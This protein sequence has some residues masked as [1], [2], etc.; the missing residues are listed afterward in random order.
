MLLKDPNNFG[1]T[2]RDAIYANIDH[3]KVGGTIHRSLI[4]KAIDRI[5][6]PEEYWSHIVAMVGYKKYERCTDFV[7]QLLETVV[8]RGILNKILDERAA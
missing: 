2:L 4:R 1:C 5:S 3:F 7:E 6:I 8:H